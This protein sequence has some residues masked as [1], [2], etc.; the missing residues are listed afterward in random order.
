MAAVLLQSES[1][2]RY[3]HLYTELVHYM[4]L[5]NNA[6]ENNTANGVQ[7]CYADTT[8]RFSGITNRQISN[9]FYEN[10][11]SLGL[12][13]A[14]L[15][16]NP[17]YIVIYKA[18]MPSIIVESA[19]MSNADDLELLMDDDF[20]ERLAQKICDSALEVLNASAKSEII[21]PAEQTAKTSE[22][23]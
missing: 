23:E 19:F 7:I 11:A 8:T 22:T 14:G 18:K 16:N 13:K 17:R 1:C 12:R 3:L 4:S 2:T 6:A 20:I 10:I 21:N 15:L 9:I 5:H